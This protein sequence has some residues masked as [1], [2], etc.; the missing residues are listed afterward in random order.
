MRRTLIVICGGIVLLGCEPQPPVERI[1]DPLILELGGQAGR[2]ADSLRRTDPAAD[3][4]AIP[5]VPPVGSRTGSEESGPEPDPPAPVRT[6]RTV[7]LQAGGSLVGLCREWLGDGNRWREVMNLNGWTE[8]DL[9]RL[10]IGT[11]VTL[12][13]R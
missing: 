3:T 5:V 7:S 10:P 11:E 12:P 2:L 6:T 8:A 9:R 13:L 4:V 1:G